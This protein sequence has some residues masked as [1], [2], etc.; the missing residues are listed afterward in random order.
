MNKLQKLLAFTVVVGAS[1]V[2]FGRDAEAVT[3]SGETHSPTAYR[4]LCTAGTPVDFAAYPSN[5]SFDTTTGVATYN[6]NVRWRRCNPTETRAYAVYAGPEMCPLSGFYGAGP[7]GAVTDCV[8]YIGNPPYNN[9]GSSLTC[10]GGT[11]SDCVTSSFTGARRSDNQPPYAAESISIPMSATNAWWA[12]TPNAPG[13]WTISNTMCQFYKTGA[14]FTTY[15]DNRCITVSITVSWMPIDVCANIPGPQ[16]TVPPGYITDGAG[17]CYPPATVSCNSPGVVES[18]VGVP[19]DVILG[20]SVSDGIPGSTLTYD[21]SL[22]TPGISAHANPVDSGT[23]TIPPPPIF[24][25][26]LLTGSTLG[27]YPSNYT[28]SLSNGA[29]VT[30]TFSIRIVAKPYFILRDGDISAGI[31]VCSSGWPGPFPSGGILTSWSTASGGGAGTNLAAFALSAIDGFSSAQSPSGSTPPIGLSFSNT[32]GNPTYGGSFGGGIACPA[33]YYGTLPTDATTIIP[34]SF[35]VP[36]TKLAYRSTNPAPSIQ[37]SGPVG[38]ITLGNRPIIYVDNK[39]V[40]ITGDIMFV[41]AAASTISDIRSFYL[42]VRGGNIYIDPGVTQLDGVYIAQPDA[43]GNEGKIYTCSNSPSN[44][45]PSATQLNKDNPTGCQRTLTVNGAFI[46][47]E[48]KLYR[49]I[50]SLS[51]GGPAEIFNYT[52]ATWLAAPA[53]IGKSK[54]G[55]YDAITSLPPIL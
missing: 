33:D 53:S 47:K 10:P 35:V 28:V 55:G 41:G 9:P 36:N 5:V 26:V 49:S 37:I 3:Y 21:T 34:A 25:T 12:F 7:G 44:G 18:E 42:V 50:G 31:T 24:Y 16:L 27:T 4:A 54:L 11:N 32:A 38:G 46:A 48:L 2:L 13:S 30:C 6:I 8:K 1:F 20:F 43:M 45:P 19:F 39:N 14:N 52:P 15:S 17:N 40:R 51:L 22:S 23:V 29:T